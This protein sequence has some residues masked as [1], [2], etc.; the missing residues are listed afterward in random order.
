MPAPGRGPQEPG[1]RRDHGQQ[2]AHGAAEP[3]SC[4]P[5]PRATPTARAIRG[6]EAM[7]AN[8]PAT[9]CPATAISGSAPRWAAAVVVAL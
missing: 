5:A 4:S 9:F 8:E 2:G 7:I 6:G 1:D 3:G